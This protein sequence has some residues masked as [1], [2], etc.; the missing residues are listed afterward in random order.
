M[1]GRKEGRK[2]RR[3]EPTTRVGWQRL[4]LFLP[5]CCATLQVEER[6][7]NKGWVI[8][9]VPEGEKLRESVW[10]GEEGEDRYGE[11]ETEKRRGLRV[12]RV[13]SYLTSVLSQKY[14]LF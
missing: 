11:N 13:I 12:F 3:K 6:R 9:L 2:E 4:R 1:K 5:L 14:V 7:R 8:I 10:L